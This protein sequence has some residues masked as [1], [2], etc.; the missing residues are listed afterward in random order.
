MAANRPFLSVKKVKRSGLILDYAESLW[1]YRVM[2]G[3]RRVGRQLWRSFPAQQRSVAPSAVLVSSPALNSKCLQRPRQV[4]SLSLTRREELL[5][6]YPWQLPHVVG[7]ASCRRCFSSITDSD[8]HHN[9]SSRSHRDPIDRQR[10]KYSSRL[11][12]GSQDGRPG[13]HNRRSD[14]PQR[15]HWWTVPELVERTN[16]L[17]AFL[18]GKPLD[19]IKGH[20]QDMIT[21]VRADDLFDVLEAW[22]EVAKSRGRP[23]NRGGRRGGGLDAALQAQGL[24]NAMER[25]VK[26]GSM[27]KGDSRPKGS[28]ASSGGSQS[29]NRH[30]FAPYRQSYYDVVLQSYAV[31][32]GGRRA[33]E[34]AQELLERMIKRCRTYRQYRRE[35]GQGDLGVQRPPEP[36]LKAFNIVT[37]CWARSGDSAAGLQAQ[38][39]VQIMDS[40]RQECEG[41]KWDFADRPYTGCH[42][43]E[44]TLANLMHAW[45]RSRHPLAPERTMELLDQVIRAKQ[46]GDPFPDVQL[47]IFVFNNVIQAWARSGRG[48]EGARGAERILS[49]A[50]ELKEN[51]LL[52]EWN[53]VPSERTYALVIDA[54]ARCER[55]GG[56][57]EAAQRAEDILNNMVRLYCE[58]LEV[59]P[60]TV[61]FTTC[62]NAWGRCT[63][64]DDAPDRAEALFDELVQLYD[65]TGDKN[66]EPDKKCCS[67]L[68][69]AWCK[70]IHRPGSI[71]RAFEVLKKI[72]RFMAP[73]LFL[74]TIFLDGLAKR[75][76]GKAAEELLES[77]YEETHQSDPSQS[78]DLLGYNCVIDAWARSKDPDKAH[79]ASLVL[80]RLIQRFRDGDDHLKPD[81]YIFAVTMKACATTRGDTDQKRKALELAFDLFDQVEEF[82]KRSHMIY[83]TLMVAING[84]AESESERVR[85]LE[86]W[87]KVTCEAGQ[88][89]RQVVVAMSRGVPGFSERSNQLK[90]EWSANVPEDNKPDLP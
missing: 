88:V 62:I 31:C 87:F 20:N 15:K 75:G 27:D 66:F 37:S 3:P 28:S 79:H 61:C 21:H 67:A 36:T 48:E 26:F 51:G 80:N 77:L 71:D 24:L 29:N 70:A 86:E 5:A 63:G 13:R 33:A 10:N 1:A 16:Y 30:V 69:S 11:N 85:L 39:V 9:T 2:R 12:R 76:N 83:S 55:L 53:Q 65:E 19:K 44:K 32:R 34:L 43:N 25:Q 41:L 56:T 4:L 58:G 7:D 54:W 17:I 59:L 38:K 82:D 84:L 22:M 73:D 50:V 68:V 52:R 40:W 47:D 23:Q 45:T 6:H 42:R 81:A 49:W 60:N 72:D 89:S 90:A 46:Q 8:F 18:D 14:D 35:T 78:P 57:G 64:R 74:Y